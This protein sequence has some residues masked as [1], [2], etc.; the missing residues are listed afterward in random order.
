MK[1]N[2]FVDLPKLV[3]RV[4]LILWAI[5]GI[6]LIMKYCFNIWYPIIVNNDI[7]IEIGVFLDNTHILSIPGLSIVL[8]VANMIAEIFYC[9]NVIIAYLICLKK[10]KL[11]IKYIIILVSISII[12]CIIKEIIAIGFICEF[13]LLIIIPTIINIKENT[14]HNK[15]LN[16]LFA[17]IVNAICFLWQLSILLIRN[18]NDVLTTAPSIIAI[19][20]QLDY[21]IFLIIFYIGVCHMGIWGIWLFGKSL[22]ELKAMKAEEEKKENPDKDYIAELE[23]A[24]ANKKEDK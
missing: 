24:I 10:K 2:K 1:I 8:K 22:T 18:I 15:A 6:L 13:I 3:R 5:L 19:I 21:Y 7:L 17:L 23:M 4:W 9:F 20:M 11:N 12:V 16:I 14:F